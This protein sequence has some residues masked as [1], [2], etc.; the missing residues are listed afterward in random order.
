MR[1]QYRLLVITFL[2]G[3]CFLAGIVVL[4]RNQQNQL[5]T[6]VSGRRDELE[7]LFRRLIELEEKELETVTFDYTYWD[8]LVDFVGTG[9]PIWGKNILN[10]SLDSYALNAIWVYNTDLELVYQTTNLPGGIAPP[11]PYSDETI[12][13]LFSN[14][15]KTRFAFRAPDDTI[16]EVRG[17]TIHP[18]NDIAH[19]TPPRGYFFVGRAWLAH[20][21][22]NVSQISGA[23]VSITNGTQTSQDRSGSNQI[24]VHYPLT[25]ADGSVLAYVRGEYPFNYLSGFQTAQSYSLRLFITAAGLL[26]ALLSA[27]FIL[28]IATP[29]RAIS[30]SLEQQKPEIIQSLRQDR[31]EFGR[32]ANLVFDSFTQKK[33]LAETVRLQQEMESA[34][35]ASEQ[36]HRILA[37][38]SSDITFI[39]A[40]DSHGVMSIEWGADLITRETGYTL[41]G[42]ETLL[43]LQEIVHPDQRAGLGSWY[44]QLLSLQVVESELRIHTRGG[45]LRWYQIKLVPRREDGPESSL[46]VFGAARDITLQK[47]AQEA[48]HALV[49]QSP[50]GL[51]IVQNNLIAFANPAF[52]TMVGNTREELLAQNYEEIISRFHPEDFQQYGFQNMNAV[53][54]GKTKTTSFPIRFRHTNGSWRW[55]EVTGELAEYQGQPAL[56][57]VYADITERR[58][59]EAALIEQRE[60]S[61][62]LFSTVSSMILV[63]DRQG[64][65]STYNPAARLFFGLPDHPPSNLKLW[66]LITADENSPL[67]SHNFISTYDQK[68]GIDNLALDHLK[69]GKRHWL[70][71]SHRHLTNREGRPAAMIASINDITENRMRERQHE[72]VAKIAVALRGTTTR[73]ETIR[74][75]LNAIRDYMDAH[76]VSIVFPIPE[77]DEL[78][79]EDSL[80]EMEDALTS[81]RLPAS[82]SIAGDVLRSGQAFFCNDPEQEPRYALK[83]YALRSD[84]TAWSP[85]ISEDKTVGLLIISRKAAIDPAD[86]LMFQPVADMAAGAIDRVSHSDQ[87]QRRIQQLSALQSIN[88]AIGAS[89]DLRLTLNVLTVQMTNQLGVDA[90]TVFLRNPN[91]KLLRCVAHNGF[92]TRAMESFQLW[93]GEGQAGRV[94]ME[95]RSRHLYDPDGIA[96]YFVPVTT[97]TGED[98]VAYDAVPLVVKGEVK[99]VIEAFHRPPYNSTGEWVQLLEA[100]ALETA[101]A[102]DNAE[103]LEKLQRSNQDLKMAYDTTIE[104]WARSLEQFGI[105]WGKHSR[106]V[107]DLTT[108]LAQWMGI[109]GDQLSNIRYGALLHDIGKIGI[110]RSILNKPDKLNAEEWT[111]VK[112]H[113]RYAFEILH[114]IPFLRSALDIPYYHHERWNGSGYPHGLKGDEIPLSARIFTVIDIFDAL[115]SR[116]PYGTIWSEEEALEYLRETAGREV[117]P[118]VAQAF[119]DMYPLLGRN[120]Q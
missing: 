25:A 5:A 15:F 81:L 103:M 19:A 46:R 58:E 113:P 54:L 11:I 90:V 60:Y 91:T 75:I 36:Q 119:L 28:W 21:M 12:R 120:R 7:G 116:R 94:A 41:T 23:K 73:K 26:L 97:F 99:G 67:S 31:G 61:E 13:A 2:L 66:D 106:R 20:R 93:E 83:Q 29:L 112:E 102:I 50:F 68:E 4:Q 77:T 101:I 62:L 57:I 72:T 85:L 92:R 86:I 53:I 65:I 88:L 45:D 79:M 70:S 48:Y 98:F 16:I 3:V 34:L 18:T 100:L 87:A 35:R 89:L 44:D 17:A 95:R 108:K 84:P 51:S 10:S 63:M 56:Q 59:A 117:D 43:A 55:L 47:A 104:G 8:E 1:V 69:E 114:D 110:P 107:V 78:L 37:Q 96:G 32:I 24:L 52:A 118:K 71:W 42:A 22:E 38:I 49:D 6:I 80:G 40:Y 111:V 9:D 105:E 27:G 109:S 14:D 76:T 64:T 74:I 30:A 82:R 33:T 39:L 115:T